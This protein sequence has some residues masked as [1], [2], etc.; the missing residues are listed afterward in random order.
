MTPIFR[1]TRETRPAAPK[2][3]DNVARLIVV[4]SHQQD[5]RLPAIATARRQ[6]DTV[7][8]EGEVDE[9]FADELSARGHRVASMS[10]GPLDKR[11]ERALRGYAKR[12]IT[13]TD[14]GD[15]ARYAEIEA[16]ASKFGVTVDIY[17][18]G[19]RKTNHRTAA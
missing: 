12:R 13:I 2:P 11:I 10:A 5:M 7:L 1:T 18:D 16:W 3:V 6:R 4:L 14:P 9:T 8:V 17:F 15:A 19:A